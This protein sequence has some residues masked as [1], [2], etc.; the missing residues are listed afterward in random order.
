LWPR[1]G[2]R[3][4]AGA[5]CFETLLM[6]WIG[7]DGSTLPVSRPFHYVVHARGLITSAEFEVHAHK[8]G[9]WLADR[10]SRVGFRY[11]G[12]KPSGFRRGSA[13][14]TWR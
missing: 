2:T 12:R 9:T 14:T 1:G 11:F 10:R 8:V 6:R 3:L 5:L 7:D 13:P 4:P